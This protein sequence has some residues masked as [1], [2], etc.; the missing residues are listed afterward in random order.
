[1]AEW[2][3]AEDGGYFCSECGCFV[4]DYWLSEMPSKCKKCG[5]KMSEKVTFIVDRRY[6]LSRLGDIQYCEDAKYPKWL[7]EL[8]GAI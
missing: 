7:L 1:M 6:R 8:R 2:I 3:Q 5:S 4:D